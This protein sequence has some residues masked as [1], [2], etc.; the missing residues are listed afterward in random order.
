MRALKWLAEP[1]RSHRTAPCRKPVR[2]E[3]CP[4]TIV[5]AEGACI[6]VCHLTTD[7]FGGHSETDSHGHPA[8]N[9]ARR[10]AGDCVNDAPALREAPIRIG[11]GITG[12][13]VTKQT[14]G[15]RGRHLFDSII[16]AVEEGCDLDDNMAAMPGILLAGTLASL[17]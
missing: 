9:T 5:A 1:M 15:D 16:A 13:A 6:H 17:R 12:T 7:A 14:P 8:R 2:R 11:K 3:R 4:E 10:A